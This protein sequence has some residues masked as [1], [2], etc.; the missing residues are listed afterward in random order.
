MR[1]AD[2]TSS[3]LALHLFHPVHESHRPDSRGSPNRAYFRRGRFLV[4]PRRGLRFRPLEEIRIAVTGP[5]PAALRELPGISMAAP[6]GKTEVLLVF[7][8][9]TS[10][11]VRGR[12]EMVLPVPPEIASAGPEALRSWLEGQL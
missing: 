2:G 6:G 10:R 5:A 7:S 1:I 12:P 4:R 9:R 8:G 3:C 11:P